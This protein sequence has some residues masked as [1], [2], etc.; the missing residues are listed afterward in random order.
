MPDRET[1]QAEALFHAA[2]ELDPDGR[3]AYLTEACQGN[4]ALYAEVTSL[5]SALESS[6]G[7]LGDPILDVGMKLLCRDSEESMVGKSVGSYKI[8]AALGTGGMGEVYLAEDIR[9][10]RKV[11]LKF[12]SREFVG[13]NWAKRQLIREAQAVAMLDSSLIGIR[14]NPK[15]VVRVIVWPFLAQLKC[16]PV[17]HTCSRCEAH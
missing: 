13:D 15:D 12:L 7:F 9:L 14:T 5:M 17:C 2:L 8:L 16:P 1:S 11:A 3:A 6:D 4:Q 10:G